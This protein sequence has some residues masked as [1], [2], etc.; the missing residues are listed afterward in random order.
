MKLSLSAIPLL[1]AAFATVSS[2]AAPLD[3]LP[4]QVSASSTSLNAARQGVVQSIA[5]AIAGVSAITA[6]GGDATA[7]SNA[8]N[9]VTSANSRIGQ[10]IRAGQPPSAQDQILSGSGT[11]QA[12]V[13]AD[14][15][16]AG[17]G[18]NAQLSSAASAVQ[19]ALQNAINFEAQVVANLPADARG[20][21]NAAATGAAGAQANTGATGVEVATGQ[22]GAA[23]G[24]VATGGVEVA[25]GGQVGAGG[26][27]VA[28]GAG[29][30]ANTGAEVAVGQNDGAAGAEA[31]NQGANQAGNAG[32][33]AG[34][35]DALNAARQGVVQSIR[36]A[37]AGLQAVQAAGGDT[38]RVAAGLR[39]VGNAIRRIGQSIQSGQTPRVRD[40]IA[41]VAGTRAAKAAAD[42]LVSGAGQNA[43]LAQAAQAVQTSLQSAIDF[44]QQV[45]ANLPNANGG[46]NAAAGGAAGQA[47]QGQG[48]GRRR[49]RGRGRGRRFGRGRNRNGNANAGAA[50]AA[51]GNGGANAALNTARQG[52]VQSLLEAARGA[53]AVQAAG[54]DPTALNNSLREVGGAIRRLGGQIAS[55]QTPSAQDQIIT[56]RATQ[57][58]VR[59]ADALAANVGDNADL[60]AAVKTVQDALKKAV[61]FEGQV[62]DNLPA[63]A[64]QQLNQAAAGGQA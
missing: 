26:V 19:S 10:S 7:L 41:T 23:G 54:G 60:S 36:E 16:V 61:D 6:A 56:G 25:T 42:E 63:E 27:E 30:A 50:A 2:T 1:L 33:A 46:G 35:Q 18:G 53:R 58:A 45:A 47:G 52:V 28:T 51:G 12:K 48:R 55:G 34:G 11:Q 13:A 17:A 39:T 22:T 49:G 32:G 3:L 15:L 8:L 31:A 20:R 4:R 9:Q 5:Q 29:Q 44:E 57:D 64:R 40:Q 24:E 38:S 43:Q 21:L 37:A 14:A 59:A 62:R